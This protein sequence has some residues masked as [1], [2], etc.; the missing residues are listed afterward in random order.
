MKWLVFREPTDGLW[1]VVRATF[2]ELHNDV[3]IDDDRWVAE[4]VGTWEHAMRIADFY[5]RMDAS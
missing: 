4:G 3:T 1:N 2:A 5:S